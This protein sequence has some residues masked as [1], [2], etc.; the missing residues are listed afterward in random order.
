MG[1]K[2]TYVCTKY[3]MSESIKQKPFSHIFRLKNLLEHPLK[4]CI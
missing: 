2:Y 1:S 4:N 3:L